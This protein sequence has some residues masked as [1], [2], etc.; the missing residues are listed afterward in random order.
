MQITTI[1][2]DLAKSVLST[3]L[4]RPARLWFES[5][6]G[7]RRCCI[8]R[9]VALLPGRHGGLRHVA[10]LGA[11]VS[12]AP[13]PDIG[14]LAYSITSSA[15]ASGAVGRLEPCALAVDNRSPTRIW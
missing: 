11:R 1:G 13:D 7:G 12:K 6:F 14:R 4:M 8:S 5:R 3:G 2:L 10:S 15:R 9:Q